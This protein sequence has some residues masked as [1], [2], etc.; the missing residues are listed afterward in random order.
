MIG[1]SRKKVKIVPYNNQWKEEYIK[2][3][4]LLY[5]LVGKYVLDIQHVGS[6]SIEGLDA[7]HIIDIAIAVKSLEN[8]ENFKYLLEEIGYS[9]RENAG[10]LGRLFFAKGSENLR[11]HYLHIEVFNSDIWKNHIYFRN[12]LRIHTEYIL[13]YSK[14]KKALA[15]KYKDDR[16]TYTKEKDKFITMILKK[17]KDEFE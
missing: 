11:T 4:K 13:E 7:K 3:E 5:S 2:E 9:F 17:A 15:I 14:L 8:V 1:L 6:T 12:Y 10:V 16:N